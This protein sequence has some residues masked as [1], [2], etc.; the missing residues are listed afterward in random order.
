MSSLYVRSTVEGWLQD[1]AMTLPFYGTI[2]NEENP[3]DSMWTTASFDATYRETLTFC[4]GIVEEEG[5]IELV[6]FAPP[7]EGYA[8]LMTA[9][10]ADVATL[11]AQRDATH[12]L[13]LRSA[14]APMEFSGGTARGDYAL[15][16][17]IE[18]VYYP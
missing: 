18:Y 17:Y 15:A 9:L 13:V 10:E 16:V 7:G 1:P 5:E 3:A 8:N 4:D 2:N 12:K 14:T 6:F 11:M